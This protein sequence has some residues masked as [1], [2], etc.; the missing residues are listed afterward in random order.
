M[1]GCRFNRFLAEFAQFSFRTSDRKW[2]QQLTFIVKGLLRCIWN[3]RYQYQWKSKGP[4]LKVKYD[5]LAYL[6]SLSFV[7]DITT[8]LNYLSLKNFRASNIFGII[9]PDKSSK[10]SNLG[11][12]FTRDI[13]CLF[14]IKLLNLECSYFSAF[15]FHLT[16]NIYIYRSCCKIKYI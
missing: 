10:A 4:R 11:Q 12:Y 16:I 3:V 9:I 5:M 1:I 2:R 14:V 15:S 6:Y 13:F 8:T 7:C